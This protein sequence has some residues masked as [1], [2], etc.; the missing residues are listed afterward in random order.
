VRGDGVGR[1]D[2]PRR[3]GDVTQCDITS[4][5]DATEWA[6]Y[7]T[8]VEHPHMVQS[9]AYGEAKQAVGADK[10]GWRFDAGGWQARRLL[11][12]RGG[13]PV[14]I[15]QML[16]KCVVGFSCASRVNRGPLFLGEEP[17]DEVVRDVYKTLRRHSRYR[18]GVLVLAPALPDGPSSYSLLDDLGYRP[19]QMAGWKSCRVDLRGGE[20]QIR[21]NLASSWRNRLKAAER[22]GL[23]ITVSASPDDVGWMIARHVENQEAKGFTYP[24]PALVRAVCDAAPQDVLV[25]KALHEGEAVGAMLVFLF[26]RGAEYYVGW[27]G[28]RGREVNVGNFLFYRIAVD[29]HERGRQWCDLCGERHGATEQFKRGMR[30]EHYALL[31]EW[32]AL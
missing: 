30:G 18:P 17:P 32:L 11:I 8:Q 27:T 28:P 15:C 2:L 14:A 10:T 9:W 20:E 3:G 19:R 31:N 13:E 22:S 25:Y 29:L 1:L 26:G 5:D 23:E 16:E 7:L 12:E 6:G 24:A 21:K 4:V